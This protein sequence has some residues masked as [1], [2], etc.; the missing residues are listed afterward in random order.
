MGIKDENRRHSCRCLDVTIRKEC[1]TMKSM[2][3]F[4][5]TNT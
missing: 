5:P 3:N 4:K 1:G 2:L